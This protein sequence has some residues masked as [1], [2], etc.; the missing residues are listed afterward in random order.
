M[1]FRQILHEDLGCAS[2]VVAD[3]GVAAVV[4]PKWQI[5]E[6]LELAASAGA[7]IRH[8]LETHTHADHVS[9]RGR[10]AAATGATIHLPVRDGLREGDALAIGRLELRVVA[11]PGHRP[12]HLAFVLSGGETERLLSGD[13]LLVGAVARPDLAIAARDG[14]EAL[15]GTLRRFETLGDDVEVWPGHVAGSLCGGGQDTTATSSTIGRERETN[16]LL[17]VRDREAFVAELMSASPVRPPRV[18]RVVELN[19]R[20]ARPPDLPD[21]HLPALAALVAEGACLLDVRAAEAFD[22]GHVRGSLNLPAGSTAVGNRAGWATREDERI[23]VVARSRREGESVAE[24]LL[25]AGSWNI[26]GIAAADMDGWMSH[27]LTLATAR[28]YSPEAVAAGLRA[29]RL[30]LLDVRDP[31]EWRLGHVEGSVNLPLS[32]LLDG[33]HA[34]VPRGLPLA[35]ACGAGGRAALAA[36]ILRRAGHPHVRRMLRGIPELQS[37]LST[38]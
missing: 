22:A 16:R 23:V 24:R 5:D 13:S 36:S 3:A 32:E 12:E 15:F 4:D 38:R 10:L 11:A 2:Y 17:A 30:A 27:G 1:M 14:A 28:A 34:P 20:G 33:R 37:R 19:R 18:S 25:A 9:G 26:A 29:G 6:Y 21:L 35:V 7:E 31:P 8:I